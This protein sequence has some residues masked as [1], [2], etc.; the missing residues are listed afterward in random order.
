M[1]ARIIDNRYEVLG[2]LGAGGMG[3]VYKTRDL[4]TQTE[5]A[6]KSITLGGQPSG[7]MPPT[8]D[9]KARAMLADEFRIA[10]SLYHPNILRTLDY[11][12]DDHGVPYFT[13]PILDGGQPITVAAANM[14]A[15][16]KLGILRQLLTALVYLHRHRVIH[17]D[18]KPANVWIEDDGTV[19][20]L[21]FGIAIHE[22]D[23]T[24]DTVAGT[25]YY[26]APEI[27]LTGTPSVSSDLYSVGVMAYE[28]FSGQLPFTGNISDMIQSIVSDPPP[29]DA[30]QADAP[31]KDLI[32]RLLAKRPQHRPANATAALQELAALGA[33]SSQ[34]EAPDIRESF[35]QHAPFIGRDSEMAQFK[36]VLGH[37][38]SGIGGGMLIGGESGVGKS[39]LLEEYRVQALITGA[40]VLHGQA[41]EGGGVRYQLWRDVLPRLIFATPLTDFEAG[42]LLDILPN[43]ST[44]LGRYIPDVP[45]LAGSG[46]NSRL[47]ETVA[48]IFKRQVRPITLFLED[49]QWASESLDVV[50]ALLPLTAQHP[51]LI[52][53]SYRSE[54]RPELPA[55]LP[56]MQSVL[57]APFSSQ[58]MLGLCTA[59][60]GEVKAKNPILRRLESETEGN[61]FFAVEFIRALAEDVG[62]L[63]QVVHAALP[64]HLQAAGVERLLARR[65]ERLPEWG[66]PL[67]R[68]AAVTGRR[69]DLKILDYVLFMR[70]ELLESDSVDAWLDAC[71][72]AQILVI[73]GE[74]WQFSHDKLREYVL[75]QIPADSL[76][77]LHRSAAEALESLYPDDRGRAEILMN[78]WRVA[79]NT[80]KE[81]HYAGMVIE[82]KLW[83]SGDYDQASTLTQY[84]LTQLSEDDARRV[85]LL[86]H[87]SEIGWRTGNNE[88]AVMYGEQAVTLGLRYKAYGKVGR[89]YGNLGIAARMR[90][91]YELSEKHLND[92]LKIRQKDNDDV[93]VSRSLSNLGVL[94]FQ[95]GKL[96]DAWRYY[97]R[98]IK[99]QKQRGEQQ[100]Y[101]LNLNNLAQISSLRGDP[102][103][104][105]RYIKDALEISQ[106]IG[107]N[108][109]IASAQNTL[110]IIALSAN[111]INEARQWLQSSLENFMKIHDRYGTAF[112]LGSLANCLAL[113][114]INLKS[115]I[116]KGIKLAQQIGAEGFVLS[117][118]TGAARVYYS[119]HQYTKALNLIAEI[120]HHP[121]SIGADKLNRDRF[122]REANIELDESLLTLETYHSVEELVEQVLRDWA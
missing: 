7:G 100:G 40:Q 51:L 21:D 63:S 54:E 99:I 28:M 97:Q 56:D 38:P 69:V 66:L 24:G 44:L 62:S 67:L 76:P 82:W 9:D 113:D 26:I 118:L 115:V 84:A 27:F 59:V 12:F 78:H 119:R 121:E 39:R 43:I 101:A 75:G 92:S 103:R 34:P 14:D 107:H 110:G 5:V 94:F 81:L 91:D 114:D 61:A 10:A 65:I 19:K 4:L 3:V 45:P 112:T 88:Q 86:N 77:R 90:G 46:Q 15:A 87:M 71:A 83:T 49:L 64:E 25:L 11:G 52:V 23:L 116:I 16:Q 104:A 108:Y 32:G 55:R 89:S 117:C 74:G 96:D 109:A 30:V 95:M 18:L 37:L 2:K 1:P 60:L 29:I 85:H 111:N 41:A 17:R 93:G 50:D 22:K 105:Q 73:L 33:H 35:L 106:S 102:Q 31:I 120:E 42:I 36:A 98:A 47:I 79:G 6:L 122:F 58:E 70:P 80:E 57:L 68:L 20:V 48:E 8:F 53:G 72:A 13:M